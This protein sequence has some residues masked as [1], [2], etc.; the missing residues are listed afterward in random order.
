MNDHELKELIIKMNNGDT[1]MY[2]PDIK[3][4]TKYTDKELRENVGD[5]V[6]Q[7]IL[8]ERKFFFELGIISYQ[9]YVQ[10]KK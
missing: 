2:G 6:Y 5:D 1:S 4:F 10:K 8:K 7:Y 3:D 9:Q